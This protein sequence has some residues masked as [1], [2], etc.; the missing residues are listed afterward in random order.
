M[1]VDVD[2]EGFLKGKLFKKIGLKI[3]D[4]CELFFE[5]V[6]VFKENILGEEGKG[7]IYMMI[8]LLREWLIIVL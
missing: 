1:V 6:K 4:I 3:S 5:D 8:E 7:F 2:L